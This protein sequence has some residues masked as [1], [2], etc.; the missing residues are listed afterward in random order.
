VAPSRFSPPDLDLGIGPRAWIAEHG[1]P[2]LV[3]DCQK[4]RLQYRSL[5]A[6]LPG[7]DLH[8]AMKALSHPAALATLADEGS[9]FDTSSTGE[10]GLVAALGVPPNRLINTHPIKSSVDILESL[11]YGCTT[12]VVDNALEMEKFVPHRDRVSIVLRLGFRSLDA[13]VNLSKKFGCALDEAFAL[14]ELGR[15]L[16]LTVCGL[17][18]HVGSQCGSPQGHVHA[19]RECLALIER[20]RRTHLAEIRLLD[21]GGGFPASYATEAPSIETFCAPIRVALADVPKDVR[22]VAEPGRYIAA[23]AIEGIATVI[24]KARRGDAFWYY[25]DDGVYGSFNGRVY[26]PDVHYPL[27]AICENPG[28]HHPSV[29]AG[30]TCDSIDIIAEDAWLPELEIGDLIVGNA[31]GAYTAGS[32]TEFNSIPKTKILVLNGPPFTAAYGH[33]R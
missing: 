13:V 19:I 12:F 22:I 2:L 21:I 33:Q 3:L 17:S 20:V 8:Y 6:S 1:S 7:V 30:P 32:A 5:A 24:G 26:D 31:M 4:I 14:L 16:G 18:F 27:R 9:S 25:L 15:S 11:R 23:P 28:K 10:L 29:L